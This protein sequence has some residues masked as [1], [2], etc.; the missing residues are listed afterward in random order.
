[1]KMGLGLRS[2]QHGAKSVSCTTKTLTPTRK[3]LD[4]L[5]AAGHSAAGIYG[6]E[7][8]GSVGAFSHAT[9]RPLPGFAG[10]VL[11][12]DLTTFAPRY[13]FGDLDL[14][15]Y[16]ELIVGL[17]S[18]VVELSKDVLPAQVIRFHLQ[19]LAD[20]QFFAALGTPLTEVN[21]FQKVAVKG[22]W[23]YV[24]KALDIFGQ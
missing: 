5:A 17:F 16:A 1:M 3:V 21:L 20:K 15:E 6:L 24:T 14:E 8:N 4:P 19:S 22:M 12:V 23:M 2:S 18:G 9:C 10:P 7:V 11:S 13:D